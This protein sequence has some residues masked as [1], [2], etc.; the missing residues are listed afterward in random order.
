MPRSVMTLANLFA[1]LTL[2]IAALVIAPAADA[3]ACAPDSLVAYQILSED[4]AQD[5][6]EHVP[7]DVGGDIHGHCH[8]P[9]EP[10]AC[11]DMQIAKPAAAASRYLLRDDGAV[12]FVADGL[13]RP[14]RG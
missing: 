4:H 2:I 12:S 1:T 10:Q 6:A 8:H 13:M 14:P 3:A 7:G 9:G 11:G 5:D